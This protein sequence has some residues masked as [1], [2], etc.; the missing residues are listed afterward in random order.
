MSMVDVVSEHDLG[1]GMRDKMA[2]RSFLLLLL[3]S[4]RITL[5][6]YFYSLFLSNFIDLNKIM[7]AYLK[8]YQQKKLKILIYKKVIIKLYIS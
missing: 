8:I 3:K 4:D 1:V 6:N 5:S 2:L 7:Y